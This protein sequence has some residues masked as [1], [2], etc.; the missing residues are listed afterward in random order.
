MQYK[1][2]HSIPCAAPCAM[3]GGG[4]HPTAQEGSYSPRAS[5]EGDE[6][7]ELSFLNCLRAGY[8]GYSSVN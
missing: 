3:G 8:S 5:R 4:S 2:Q 1:P 6:E 7:S